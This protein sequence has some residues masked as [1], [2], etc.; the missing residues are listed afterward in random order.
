MHTALTP[1]FSLFGSQSE[2]QFRYLVLFVFFFHVGFYIIDENTLSERFIFWLYLML[3]SRT[4][5]SVCVII[6][7]I[8][9][10]NIVQHIVWYVTINVMM[11]SVTDV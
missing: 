8:I 2:L 11:C 10:T 4:S 5:F 6:I 1:N 9:I 3:L 7:V